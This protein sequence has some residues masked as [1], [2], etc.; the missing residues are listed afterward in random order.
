LVSK[1]IVAHQVR[2]LGS[3]DSMK[4]AVCMKNRKTAEH[5]KDETITD[6]RDGTPLVNPV[7][8]WASLCITIV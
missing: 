7:V 4:L 3:G 2:A 1:A 5:R 6:Q 8:F